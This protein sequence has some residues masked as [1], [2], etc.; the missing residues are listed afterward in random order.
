M[1]QID[2]RVFYKTIDPW[3]VTLNNKNDGFGFVPVW[4]DALNMS[5][6][7][8]TPPLIVANPRLKG[9]GDL[10]DEFKKSDGTTVK[11]FLREKAVFKHG[12]RMGG[13]ESAELVELLPTLLADQRIFFEKIHAIGQ[14]I[15]G[16]AFD[17]RIPTVEKNVDKCIDDIADAEARSMTAVAKVQGEKKNYTKAD[18]KKLMA[19]DVELRNKIRAEARE[20]FIA[21]ATYMFPNPADYDADGNILERGPNDRNKRLAVYLKRKVYKRASAHTKTPKDSMPPLPAMS[22]VHPCAQNWPALL[23]TVSTHYQYN[24]FVFATLEGTIDREHFIPPGDTKPIPAYEWCPIGDNMRTLVQ[25]RLMF[26]FF[27]MEQS[28]GV[29]AVPTVNI[30][31]I[32]QQ[33]VARDDGVMG[34]P[35]D[36]LDKLKEKQRRD[37]AET[38]LGD[39]D[40]EPKK[41][42]KIE[43]DGDQNDAQTT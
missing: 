30:T 19:D 6:Q 38:V 41:R 21:G 11:T 13:D 42:Q 27:K 26:S 24:P 8:K 1:A 5:V 4:R 20:K 14:A 39:D 3:N 28:Y 40:D 9:E 34:I 12:L 37:Q 22:E 29:K 10:G 36:V 2:E 32:D 23:K 17:K 7:I 25:E 16:A 33:R 35:E 31:I 43:H 18:V 15:L